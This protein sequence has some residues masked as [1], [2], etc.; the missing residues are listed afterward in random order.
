MPHPSDLEDLE[1]GLDYKLIN[2]QRVT[3]IQE[4]AAW[5]LKEFLSVRVINSL[6]MWSVLNILSTHFFLLFYVFFLGGG[7]LR[8]K[9]K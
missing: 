7:R 8:D 6:P 2:F 4:Y 1:T 3:Q 9:D 5:H